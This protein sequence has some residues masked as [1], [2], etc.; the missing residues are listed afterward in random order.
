MQI[1]KTIKAGANSAMPE[2]PAERNLK[3]ATIST[4]L[5]GTATSKK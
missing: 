2:P 1:N 3:L 4:L 5:C